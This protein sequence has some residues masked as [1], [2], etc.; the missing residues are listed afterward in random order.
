[1]V[2]NKISSII[3]LA[4]LSYRLLKKL[5]NSLYSFGDI[6]INIILYILVTFQ[7]KYCFNEESVLE[8]QH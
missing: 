5:V 2:C 1:M 3:Y 7:E 8:I 4:K 6:F